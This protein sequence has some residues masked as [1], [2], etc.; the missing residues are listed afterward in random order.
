MSSTV[1]T[2]ANGISPFVQDAVDESSEYEKILKLRD[3]IFAGNHPRLTVPAH[4]LRKLSPSPASSSHSSLPVQA[5]VQQHSSAPIQVPGLGVD[6]D[7]GRPQS[8]ASPSNHPT[9][10]ASAIH[11]A[12]L[13]KSDDLIRAETAL[14]RARLEKQLRDQFEQKRLDFRKKP[15]PA[16]AKPDFDISALLAKAL[17]AVKPISLSKEESD[18]EDENDSFDEN[19]FYSSRAPDSTPE[20]GDPSTSHPDPLNEILPDNLNAVSSQSIRIPTIRSQPSSKSIPGI[21]K[22]TKTHDRMDMDDEDDEEGEYSPP[23]AD[24][25]TNQK[26][27]G[28]HLP[29]NANARS[30][31]K[32][33]D[34]NQPDK[35]PASP[36]EPTMRIVRNHIT[37]PAAPQPSRVSPL[38]FAKDSLVS[39]DQQ[40]QNTSNR[41]RG[42]ADSRSRSPDTQTIAARNKRRKLERKAEKRAQRRSG[43]KQENVSPP[44]FHDIQPLGASKVPQPDD[45]TIVIDEPPPQPPQLLQ[46]TRYVPVPR[47]ID[48]PQRPLSR[49]ADPT[50]LS[51]PRVMSR[52]NMRPREDIDLRRVASMHNMRLEQQSE[53]VELPSARPRATSYMRVD[54][55]MREVVRE[56]PSDVDRP[57]QEVRVIRTPAPEYRE[58]YQP[59]PE[60]RYIPEPMP[61]PSRE[62]IVIDQYGRRFREIIQERPPPMPRPSP[63][64]PQ[65]TDIQHYDNHASVRANSIM[66]EDNPPPARYESDMAPPRLARPMENIGPSVSVTREI[67]E[68][69][70]DDRPTNVVSYDRS[71]RPLV[72]A[73]ST[74]GYQT[75]TRMSSVR[76]TSSYRE[77]QKIPML[78]RSNSVRPGPG[79]PRESSVFIDDRGSVRREYLPVEQSQPR[80]RVVEPES[81]SR[82]QMQPRYVDSQGREVVPAQ[83]DEGIRYVQRY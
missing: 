29:V 38:A 16:E 51:S 80:Y 58:V 24:Q 72:Y 65:D 62:R 78:S 57:L 6:R 66:M 52:N 14:Q 64:L 10:P 46:D 11:P 56:Y 79:Q 50:Q 69:T 8:T 18:K 34:L 67:Y 53:Y 76:P 13:T 48:P 74:A 68:P 30:L 2:V 28:S 83:H 43:V 33:S 44:P 37:S 42:R 20:H 55:P 9:P 61:P 3:E 21:N 54:S 45:R 27:N 60:V 32:Y 71:T 73:D 40:T 59:E 22:S 77:E 70:Y 5:K 19:S 63:Y 4:L 12:L 35:R 31:R 41:Q 1:L 23:E 15:A 26:T 36:S 81:H 25:F 82:L 49:Q 47:Y 39:Q 75:P 7:E 17:E